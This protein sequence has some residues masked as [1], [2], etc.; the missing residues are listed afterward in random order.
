MSLDD[1][2]LPLLTTRQLIFLAVLVAVCIGV[3][4]HTLKRWHDLRGK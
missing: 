1:I 2:Y 4:A 3:V